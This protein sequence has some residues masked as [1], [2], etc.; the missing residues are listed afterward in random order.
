[1]PLALRE[2]SGTL[3]I[4]PVGDFSRGVLLGQ[5]H[6]G[7]TRSQAEFSLHVLGSVAA[8]TGYPSQ[9]AAGGFQSGYSFTG[10]P[11]SGMFHT[12]NSCESC[13]FPPSSL[14]LSFPP[15]QIQTA[16]VPP[17]TDSGIF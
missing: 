1:M 8:S 5:G 17:S 6:S 7:E 10:F 2:D 3:R 15:S 11:T 9:A 4:N 14:G 13:F 16:V 12:F